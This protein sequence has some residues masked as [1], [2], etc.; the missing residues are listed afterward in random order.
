MGKYMKGR[1]RAKGDF[2]T[3]PRYIPRAHTY[4]YAKIRTLLDS[5]LYIY[6][7]F[8]FLNSQKEIDPCL[9]QPSRPWI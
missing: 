4:I 8:L 7:I 1:K 6:L 2:N 5:V 9:R 3:W